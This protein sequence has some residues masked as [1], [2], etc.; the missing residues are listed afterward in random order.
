MEPPYF[1]LFYF[2]QSCQFKFQETVVHLLLNKTFIF[3]TTGYKV[4][5]QTLERATW[6]QEWRC[7]IAVDAAAADGKGCSISLMDIVVI[8]QKGKRHR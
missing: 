7:C 1:H 6:V 2:Q 4:Y 8:Y 5:S 3:T